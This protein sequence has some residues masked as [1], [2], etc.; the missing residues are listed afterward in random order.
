MQWNNFKEKCK[1]NLLVIS[2]RTNIDVTLACEDGQQV[3]AHKVILA[4]SIPFFQKWLTRNKHN[5]PLVY[6]RGMKSENLLAFLDFLYYGVVNVYQQN[7]DSFL[8]IAEELQLKGLIGITD[9]PSVRPQTPVKKYVFTDEEKYLAGGASG[10]HR[11]RT[12]GA[13]GA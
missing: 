5:H 2:E 9:A 6:M 3:E 4:F 10:A 7:L 1:K 13:L 11:G 12:G 8:V